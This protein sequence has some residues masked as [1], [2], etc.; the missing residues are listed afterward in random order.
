V[1]R[2]SLDLIARAFSAWAMRTARQLSG[3]LPHGARAWRGPTVRGLSCMVAAVC[4]SIGQAD[5]QWCATSE[6]RF[7]KPIK[8]S[9]PVLCSHK[10]EGYSNVCAAQ[11]HQ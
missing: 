8:P 6:E 9:D 5:L 4:Q 3:A 1:R 7:S 10:T 2:V 11:S